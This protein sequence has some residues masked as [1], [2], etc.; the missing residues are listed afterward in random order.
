VLP[1]A[2]RGLAS[3][4]FLGPSL[5]CVPSAICLAIR[6][7]RRL[8]V[9]FGVI[10]L[11]Q[12]CD[13]YLNVLLTRACDEEFFGLRVAKEAQHRVFL[14]ELVDARTEFVFVGATLGLYGEGD[15]RLWQMHFGILNRGSLVPER[16]AGQRL[17]QLGNRPNIAGMQLCNRDRSFTLHYRNM[18]QF[19]IG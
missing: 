6:Y 3:C 14:H 17:S 9:Y 2:V 18:C 19:L 7:L 11:L 1:S 16:V 15:C 8:Q 12:L 4:L 5:R 13:D 10:P